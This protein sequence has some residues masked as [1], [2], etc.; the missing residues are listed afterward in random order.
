M[1]CGI[2]TCTRICLMHTI[3]NDLLGYPR[4]V[5]TV[6]QL[7]I[8]ANL[9]HYDPK[10]NIGPYTASIFKLE[11]QILVKSGAIFSSIG[12]GLL[13]IFAMV[14]L[15]F[16]VLKECQ[17]TGEKCEFSSTAPEPL[18]FIIKPTFLVIALLA[19]AIGVAIIRFGTRY[20]YKK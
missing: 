13:I 14:L 7:W 15:L 10:T 11:P 9:R 17:R 3:M 4:S 19:I 2:V 5:S 18:K 20:Y 1:S 12:I 16:P 8:L 6:L